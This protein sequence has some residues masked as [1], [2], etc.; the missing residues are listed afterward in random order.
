MKKIFRLATIIICLLIFSISSYGKEPILEY[1]FD[2][3]G[4]FAYSTGSDKTPLVL[5]NN[6]STEE[7]LHSEGG[8]GVSG[9][10]ND[11]AFDNYSWCHPHQGGIALADSEELATK[12]AG[13]KSLTLQGWFYTDEIQAS[14]L[15][16][17]GGLNEALLVR[18][19]YML[20]MSQSI[21][22]IRMRF[23]VGSTRAISN[24]GYAITKEW[25][26]FAV[27]YDKVSKKVN[28]YIGTKMQPVT[29][30]ST[31][32]LDVEPRVDLLF[33]LGGHSA[34]G[35]GMFYGLLDNIRLYGSNIDAT[36]VL[37]PEELEQ[38]RSNDI[39]LPPD[40]NNTTIE[41]NPGVSTTS[42]PIN[43]TVNAKNCFD[44][45]IS[46]QTV[47][48]IKTSGDINFES[49]SAVTDANGVA[50][51]P[52]TSITSGSLTFKAIME[53]EYV[54]GS[55]SVCFINNPEGL[56]RPLVLEYLFD[57]T[58]NYA[59]STGSD[60]TPLTLKNNRSIE[61]DLHS[62]GGLGVSGSP[63]DRAF[64]NY[65]WCEPHDGG[66]ATTD[67][68]ELAT[69]IA[70]LKSLT[71][72]GWFYTDEIQAS[73][74]TPTGGLNEALL[75]R[76]PY[77]LDMS[78]SI[79]DIRM[80]FRVGS[81]RAISNS[82]YAITKEWVFFAVTYDKVSKKVNFY[83]GTKMQ[84]VTLVSTTT[85]DVEPRE[86]LLFQLG[87]HASGGVG[88]FYGLLDNIRLYGS[89]TDASGVLTP[90]ELEKLRTIDILLL[91][92]PFTSKVE[93]NSTACM[94]D[95]KDD[96]SITVTVVDQLGNN[97]SGATVTLIADKN[98]DPLNKIT[99]SDGK[100]TFVVSSKKSGITNFTAS[101]DLGN[102]IEPILIQD[103]ASVEFIQAVDPS[104]SEINGEVEPVSA[105]GES[106][107]IVKVKLRDYDK[108]TIDGRNVKLTSDSTDFTIVESEKVTGNE[109]E[110]S[111][112]ASFSIKANESLDSI[113]GNVI[114]TV[115]PDQEGGESIT[116]ELP[117]EFVGRLLIGTDNE[118]EYSKI[119]ETQRILAPGL[120]EDKIAEN[121]I[122]NDGVSAMEVAIKLVDN[123]GVVSE[124]LVQIYEEEPQLELGDIQPTEVRTDPD[125]V[126]RFQVSTAKELSEAISINIKI[127]VLNDKANWVI[128]IQFIPDNFSLWVTETIPESNTKKAEVDEPFI[129]TFNNPI[130][131]VENETKIILTP[132]PSSLGNPETIIDIYEGALDN[133][134]IADGHSLEWKHPRLAA[135]V[136]YTAELEG[137]RDLDDNPLFPYTW[138][139][140]GTDTTPPEILIVDGKLAVQP[141]PWAVWVETDS[142]L[143][144]Q[145]TEP[146]VTDDNGYPLG[147]DV[148][149]QPIGSVIFQEYDSVNSELIFIFEA[150]QSDTTYTITVSGARDFAGWVMEP[151]TWNFSTTAQSDSPPEIINIE[152]EKDIQG[153]TK[154]DTNICIYFNKSLKASP[155]PEIIVT[156][157]EEPTS[158]V[159]GTTNFVSNIDN[160]AALVFVPER[161]LSYDTFYKVE[162]SNVC[163]SDGNILEGWSIVFL[164]EVQTSEIQSIEAD[165]EK[166]SLTVP[167]PIGEEVSLNILVPK[168]VLP[169][170]T[171]LQV[172]NVHTSVKE[173]LAEKAYYKQMSV[174]PAIYEFVAGEQEELI[175]GGLDGKLTVD[176]P[177]TDDG[178][179][180][181]YDLSGNRV[182][183]QSLKAFSWNAQRQ[184]WLPLKSVVNTNA[185]TVS[186]E[187]DSFGIL[188]LFGES[189]QAENYLSEVRLTVNPLIL[190]SDGFRNET[191]FKFR[192]AYDSYVTLELY[193][194][195]GR[196]VTTL[197]D[198][199]F[200]SYGYNGFSWNGYVNGKKLRPG[201]YFYRLSVRSVQQGNKNSESQKGIVGIY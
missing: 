54:L 152:L 24:S 96:V 181:V 78:Q 91:P 35:V 41:V 25:V 160:N 72:Q 162:L 109:G 9:S 62:E 111:G 117:I 40:L 3:I 140:K 95:G 141:V 34:G 51:F 43:V 64:D 79:E 31:T 163:D 103:K 119:L 143:R 110:D 83:I 80:R 187:V 73:Y 169:V 145:F 99:G 200:C 113:S 21:E 2:E 87:G 186:C 60:E 97:I 151:V 146:L 183:V 155:K 89:N 77:M 170:G 131:L 195:N 33:Q 191:T 122:P 68:K 70:G 100:A 130:K 172:K 61:D 161:E 105:D 112:E 36:G 116:F 69:K 135:N 59:Y 127:N 125:G 179:G 123:K 37:T 175:T 53:P 189:G 178:F 71:L 148:S 22:D 20:D 11:R 28:F 44:E 188:G 74:L 192:I 56:D 63:N 124:R 16:P 185:N 167:Q 159:I 149:L 106:E 98:I 166:Y 88:M 176:I 82:G 14:Y 171:K 154:V 174:T 157:V 52:I 147:L 1:L 121:H 75:V 30:V 13:L 81:T 164:T 29:L 199:E 132:D 26:F 128:P 165:R 39:F 120:P 168:E 107:Y 66:I 55:G 177:Y 173:E 92:D 201:I 49:M 8:M 198:E 84:P 193:D 156:K 197:L 50:T 4:M 138:R 104:E 101:V 144:I 85:L 18:G 46:G 38:I 115:A 17:T 93:A 126:A 42:K 184:E 76:G 158:N 134:W 15:T 108:Q 32:T 180:Y 118:E 142:E 129:I 19:P 182:P 7:D 137:V 48:L 102:N 139:F 133:N 58:G 67:S 86:D 136:F 5:I 47:K 153:D 114:A 196:L 23:R 57:E 150:L 190:D 94:A 45:G 10:P 12:I 65:S 27:T 6:R 90:E 194:R